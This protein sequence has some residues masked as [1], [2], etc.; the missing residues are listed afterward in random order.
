L[1]S[2]KF[3][4]YRTD[5][6]RQSQQ[7]ML[8]EKYFLSKGKVMKQKMIAA[9]VGT[10]V[11]A[12]VYAAETYNVQAGVQYIKGSVDDGTDTTAT[13]IGGTYYFK[14][15]V[16]D[17]TQP[18]MELDVLQKASNVSVQYANLS[19]ETS[20]LAKTT[21]NPIQ[22]GGTL[23]VDNFILG[24]NNTTWDKAF[25]LKSNAAYNYGIKSTSTGFNVGYWVT[26]TTA[27]SF[28]NSKDSASYTRS[29]TNLTA[30]NDLNTTTNG[31][32]SHTVTSLGGTQSL[33]LDF[34]YDQI[35]REQTASE[36]NKEY[37]AKA[38]YYPE[39]KYFVEGGYIVNTGD[40]AAHKGKTFVAGAG[41]AFTPRFAVLLST[42]KFSGDVS[43][44]KSS[45]TQT[46]LSA[47]Y[48]F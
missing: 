26:P 39:S 18:F 37:G 36:N 15:V 40:N 45:E 13:A 32:A 14:D 27:V 43:S 33:V 31:V 2:V 34:Y 11:A 20:T 19:L 22:L 38:R 24:V 9:V 42:S 23:Y 21:V 7:G 4:P 46:V 10:L 44:E 16:I 29:S 8:W 17:G 3:V 30:I 5:K 1:I 41:Y 35:K 28:V 6:I 12:N 47:G 25:T 48:R